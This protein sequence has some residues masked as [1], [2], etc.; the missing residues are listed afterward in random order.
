MVQDGHL[1]PIL[2]PINRLPLVKQLSPSRS[3]NGNQSHESASKTE[4]ITLS[5]VACNLT[6]ALSD[7]DNSLLP[8]FKK[9]LKKNFSLVGMGPRTVH[10]L[11]H[12]AN[13]ATNGKERQQSDA[14]RL[15]VI[16][17]KRFGSRWSKSTMGVLGA[18]AVTGV[19]AV[20]DPSLVKD[21]L[22]STLLRQ[23]QRSGKLERNRGI[24]VDSYTFCYE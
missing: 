18:P 2:T 5:E 22:F 4:S 17:T 13:H 16:V 23:P 12:N 20:V 10:R 7:L 24:D 11:D 14:S 21:S 3:T 1:L 19:G 9:P 15:A 8:P 6:D